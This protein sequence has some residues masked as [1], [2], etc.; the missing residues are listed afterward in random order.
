MYIIKFIK[1][2]K[3]KSLKELL[4]YIESS[5]ITKIK[6]RAYFVKHFIN[7]L[8]GLLNRPDKSFIECLTREHVI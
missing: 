4:K 1:T 6:R 5:V 3:Y 2:L 8:A 7:D